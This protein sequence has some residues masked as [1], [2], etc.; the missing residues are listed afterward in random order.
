MQQRLVVLGSMVC[1]TV[2][3]LFADVKH[4]LCLKLPRQSKPCF[5][6]YPALSIFQPLRLSIAPMLLDPVLIS[7][8]SS[9]PSSL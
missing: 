7:A 3:K 6:F 4:T 8:S 5:Y 1:V 2:Y 9:S